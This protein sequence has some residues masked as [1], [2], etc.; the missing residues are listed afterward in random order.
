MSFTAAATAALSAGLSVIAGS[1]PEKSIVFPSWM[2]TTANG[3]CALLGWEA[4]LQYL[5]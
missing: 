3:A 5:S 4:R 2:G 1:P